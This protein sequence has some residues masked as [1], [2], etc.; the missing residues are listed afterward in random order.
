MDFTA[1]LLDSWDRQCRIVKALSS[2][3]DE[4]N[5]NVKPSED[6]WSVD[7]QLAHIHGVRHYWLS[8]VDPERAKAVESSFID[9]WQTPISDL[10]K[11]KSLLDESHLAVREAV[12]AAIATGGHPV[13]GYDNPILFLQHMIWHEGWHVG[14]IVLAFRL[15]GQELP[16][17][18]EE[19]HIWS[20]WRI[21]EY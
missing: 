10:D 18:W 7:F 12:A 20:E 2:L 4:S 8:Q 14:L 15:A 16:Q 11:I 17:E 3:I 13:G 19:K 9:G 21:E 1:I 6:G 5:R